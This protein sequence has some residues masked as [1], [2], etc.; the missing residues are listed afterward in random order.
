[1]F[2]LDVGPPELLLVWQ[3]RTIMEYWAT[4]QKTL[5]QWAVKVQ[6]MTP[7]SYVKVP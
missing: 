5:M 1:M 4:V 2:V 3:G 7:R 6:K